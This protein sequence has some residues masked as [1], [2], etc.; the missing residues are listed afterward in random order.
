MGWSSYSHEDD[1]G[2]DQKHECSPVHTEV[3]EEDELLAHNI[4]SWQEPA[5]EV[6]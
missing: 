1:I 5:A 4:F 3:G 6:A 2:H